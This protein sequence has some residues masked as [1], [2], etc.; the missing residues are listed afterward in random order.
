MLIV[1]IVHVYFLRSI[2]KCYTHH[3][4]SSEIKQFDTSYI[5]LPARAAHFKKK[6]I[7]SRPPLFEQT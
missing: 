5:Q 3:D 6:Q 2:Q 4:I 7:L 1:F